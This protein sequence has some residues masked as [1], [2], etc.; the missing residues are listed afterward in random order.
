MFV[1]GMCY[2]MGMKLKAVP[3]LKELDSVSLSMLLM[4][5]VNEN[6]PTAE[7]KLVEEAIKVGAYLHRNDYRRGFRGASQNPPYFEHPLRVA[8]RLTRGLATEVSVEL[9]VAALLHDTVEDHAVDFS[10]F[11]GTDVNNFTQGEGLARVAALKYVKQHFEL[12]VAI[13]VSGLSNPLNNKTYLQHVEEMVAE[14]S[15][16]RAEVLAIKMSD[17]FDNAGSLY[18][19]YPTTGNKPALVKK[20]EPLVRVFRDALLDGDTIL[21]RVE[22][23]NRLNDIENYFQSF[24]Q[25]H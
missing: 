1:C 23:N 8:V 3:Q 17:Y 13:I 12:K 6:F 21:N 9:L 14:P 24:P 11:E 16:Y 7:V 25:P 4:E 20:Y 19:H 2:V 5:Y 15:P 10:E 18:R 22:A